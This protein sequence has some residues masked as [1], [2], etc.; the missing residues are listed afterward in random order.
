[1]MNVSGCDRILGQARP[2][3]EQ[4]Q[5]ALGQEKCGLEDRSVHTT[6]S[7]SGNGF[8]TLNQMKS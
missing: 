8:I 2:G 4:P 7:A 3:L 6:R 1:M 5:G